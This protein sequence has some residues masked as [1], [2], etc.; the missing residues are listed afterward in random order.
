MYSK[1]S[2]IIKKAG[3]I[4]LSYFLDP[5]LQKPRLKEDKTIVTEA[6]I[7]TQNYLVERLTS[8]TPSYQIVGEETASNLNDTDIEKLKNTRYIWAIDPVDGTA[9]FSHN[10][11]NWVISLGLLEYGVPIAGWIYAPVWDQL[12]YAFPDEDNAFLN[13]EELPKN[14]YCKDKAEIVDETCLMIDSKTFRKYTLKNFSGKV[15]SLGSTAFHI[16]LVAT[17]TVIASNS[18][19]NKLWD[20]AGAGAIAKRCNVNLRYFSGEE[21]NYKELLDMKHTKDDVITCNDGIFE[22]IRGLYVPIR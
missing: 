22:M 4:A 18:I 20:L 6:D 1:V 3:K 8:L 14:V 19:R 5:R 15:R 13:G 16:T 17:G 21:V 10:L 12:F 7:D 9:S 11:P 2:E